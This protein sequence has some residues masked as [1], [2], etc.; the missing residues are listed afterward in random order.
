VRKD[1]QPR[2]AQLQQQLRDEPRSGGAHAQLAQAY[3]GLGMHAEAEQ[4]YLKAIALEPSNHRF[5][6][7]LCVNYTEWKKLDEAIECYQKAIKLD[8]NHVYYLSLGNRY[9]EQGKFDEAIA[10]YQKSIEKKPRFTFGLYQLGF[11]YIK[12][13]QPA[14]AVGPLQ[15][16]LEIEPNHLQGNHALGLAYAQLGQ[17]T[18]A[19][20]QYFV[21]KDLRTQPSP[22]NFSSQFRD[23]NGHRTTVDHPQITQIGFRA[24]ES[25]SSSTSC[26]IMPTR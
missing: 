15:R 2:L 23:R 19:M 26:V 1:L 8:P 10:A 6:G 13:G 4:D 5:R 9:L 14:D 18:A 3:N 7:G 17:T 20:Q 11:V 22:I 24:L 16:L 12:N 21:L 25:L